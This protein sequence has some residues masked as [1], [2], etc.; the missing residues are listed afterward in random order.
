LTRRRWMQ[1]VKE[2]EAKF[3]SLPLLE[4][5]LKGKVED[6][7]RFYCTSQPRQPPTF[8]PPASQCL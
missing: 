4:K 8:L 7:T 6:P 3:S 1:A 2:R 5:K